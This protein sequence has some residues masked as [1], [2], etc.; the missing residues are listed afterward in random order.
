[1]RLTG[2]RISLPSR[3]DKDMKTRLKQIAIDENAWSIL[4]EVK[5]ELRKEGRNP[6]LSDAV[7]RLR[8]GEKHE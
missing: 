6:S 7:R 1:V 4:C 5:E 3:R 2:E 8:L